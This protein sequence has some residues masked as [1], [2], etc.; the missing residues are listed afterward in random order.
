MAIKSWP[1]LEAT[2]EL[3]VIALGELQN[4]K[5]TAK[6]GAAAKSDWYSK[7]CRTNFL[8]EYTSRVG[9]TAK[10]FTLDDCPNCVDNADYHDGNVEEQDGS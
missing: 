4:I 3:A 8:V 7:S 2:D 9:M 6:E 1:E 10:N 5:D